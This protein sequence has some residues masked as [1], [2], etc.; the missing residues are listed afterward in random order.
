ML[1]LQLYKVTKKHL[2]WNEEECNL[3]KYTK[4][5]HNYIASLSEEQ[6]KNQEW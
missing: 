1:N 5:I 4:N 3:K 6:S 2:Q